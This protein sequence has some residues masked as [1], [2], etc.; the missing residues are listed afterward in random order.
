M[1]RCFNGDENK[2]MVYIYF[3]ES[4]DLGFNFSK[5]GTSE[6]FSVAFLIVDEK[7]PISTLVKKVFT[8]LPQA[9]KRKSSGVLHA[10]YEKASTIAKLLHGISKKDVKIASMRLDK[11]KVLLTGNPNELYTS[12]VVTL[13]NRLYA[14]GVIRDTDEIVL[15]ASRRN[16]SENLNMI[17]SESVVRRA[18]GVKFSVSI[19]PSGND[20]CLQADYS[21]DRDPSIFN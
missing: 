3:D 5:G 7:R 4:G 6:H 15:V 2:Y 16:T 9:S 1:S 8:S 12:L 18:H 14:D 13:I 10:Y 17:F 19:I 20:K 21:A 11:H